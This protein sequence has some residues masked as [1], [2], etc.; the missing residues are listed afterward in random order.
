[1]KNLAVY[2]ALA[3]AEA[4]PLLAQ[5]TARLK[6]AAINVQA[7]ILSTKEGQKATQDLQN[8]FMPRRQALEKKQS[9]LA[10]LQAKMRAGSATMSRQAKEKLIAD[11]D[12]RTKEWNGGSQDFNDEVQREQGRIMNEVGHKMLDVIEK[13]ATQHGILLVADVSNPQSP[14]L[15]SDSSLDITNEIIKL[16]DQTYPVA[17]ATPA[18]TAPAPPAT[19]KQ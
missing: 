19:K 18:T 5:G 13:Y 10:A 7:A 14:V 2:T 9:D 8:K 3:L 17:A 11:I 4:M 12:A 1:M 15:W 16:Y 6:P